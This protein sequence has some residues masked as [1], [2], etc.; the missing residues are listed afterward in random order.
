MIFHDRREDNV[1]DHDGKSDEK[2]E[3]VGGGP[4]DD[5]IEHDSRD[6]QP[7]IELEQDE[8]FQVI[9]E[10]LKGRAE[11]ASH[12]VE[13]C[14]ADESSEEDTQQEVIAGER[15]AQKEHRPEEKPVPQLKFS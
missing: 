6:A 7:D 3:N 4:A 12:P 15:Q 1:D 2:T 13:V 11:V 9:R 14:N 5:Q 8:D 10:L